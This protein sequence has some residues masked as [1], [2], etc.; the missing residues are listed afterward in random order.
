MFF[1]LLFFPSWLEQLTRQVGSFGSFSGSGGNA[2][3]NYIKPSGVI[4]E[5]HAL[6]R[7]LQDLA[8]AKSEGA[9]SSSRTAKYEDQSQDQRVFQI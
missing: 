2:A 9:S 1:L 6:S 7:T 8:S 5:R 3:A 4:G